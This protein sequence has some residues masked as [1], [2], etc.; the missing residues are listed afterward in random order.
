MGRGL[1]D[2][3]EVEGVGSHETEDP[4]T[5]KAFGRGGEGLRRKKKVQKVVGDQS[6]NHRPDQ[7]GAKGRE[8]GATNAKG[9]E[10]R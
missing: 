1:D 6:L 8:R 9:R 2:E 3:Y 10:K 5:D 7:L 4:G